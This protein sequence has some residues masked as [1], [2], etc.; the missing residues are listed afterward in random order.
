MK[1]LKQLLRVYHSTYCSYSLYITKCHTLEIVCAALFNFVSEGFPCLTLSLSLL[2][3]SQQ[4][5][6]DTTLPY[7]PPKRSCEFLNSVC[8]CVC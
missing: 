6:E 1:A 3:A 7:K 4:G 5:I 8:V 2:N